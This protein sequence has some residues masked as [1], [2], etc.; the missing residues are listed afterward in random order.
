M[1]VTSKRFLLLKFKFEMGRK[2]VQY[3]MPVDQYR[4]NIGIFIRCIFTVF[5]SIM[6]SVAF[7]L[8][9]AVAVAFLL[10]VLILVQESTKSKRKIELL[11]SRKSELMNFALVDLSG[12]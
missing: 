1:F 12:K 6:C 9:N 7:L 5:I 4:R 11:G 2:N 3:Q 10:F 8:F